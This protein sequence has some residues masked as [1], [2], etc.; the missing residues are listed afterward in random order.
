MRKFSKFQTR[1]LKNLESDYNF[2]RSIYDINSE[3]N[4]IQI[5]DRRESKYE[6]YEWNESPIASELVQLNRLISKNQDGAPVLQCALEKLNSSFKDKEILN[7]YTH[8]IILVFIYLTC[9]CHSEIE[10]KNY[11][12]KKCLAYKKREKDIFYIYSDFLKNMSYFNSGSTQNLFRQTIIPEKYL[13]WYKKRQFC[14]MVCYD[15]IFDQNELL[16]NDI[17]NISILSQ[18]QIKPKK[19]ENSD[20]SGKKFKK[21]KK[22]YL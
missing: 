14:F 4:N 8:Y 9:S 2:F 6:Y 7:R 13:P 15:K 11:N 17:A 21:F 16:D 18:E 3:F 12:F 10:E 1:F 19:E 22:Y 5:A 20:D